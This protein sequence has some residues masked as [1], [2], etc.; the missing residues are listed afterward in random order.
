[1][2]GQ[3]M[4]TWAALTRVWLIEML[5]A[6]LALAL[7]GRTL[8][9]TRSRPHTAG[10]GRA[11]ATCSQRSRHGGLT[12]SVHRG[13]NLTVWRSD[14]ADPTQLP[15]VEERQAVAQQLGR[16]REGLP[17]SEQRMLDAMVMVAFTEQGE[18]QPYSTFYGGPA[19]RAVHLEPEPSLVQR[20]RGRSLERDALGDDDRRAP[21][22]LPRGRPSV[23]AEECELAATGRCGAW[24]S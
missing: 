5:L 10:L 14:M 15:G 3:M 24:P 13:A 20:E 6:S 19:V 9:S 22:G 4:D 2:I 1:L 21:V 8:R 11:V 12:C 17:A 23:T 18:V 7:A 16:F